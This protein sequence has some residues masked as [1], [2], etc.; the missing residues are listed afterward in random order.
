MAGNRWLGLAL[1]GLLALI[2]Q[3]AAMGTGTLATASADDGD[4]PDRCEPVDGATPVGDLPDEILTDRLPDAE[5]TVCEA[6]QTVDDVTDTLDE[7][8]AGVAEIAG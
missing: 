4:A 8:T 2:A 1:V 3:P 6:T 7:A 5:P